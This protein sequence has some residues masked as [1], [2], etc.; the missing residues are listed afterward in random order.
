MYYLIPTV[1][2]VP[3]IEGDHFETSSPL[4]P[5]RVKGLGEGSLTGSAAAVVNAVADAITPL[6]L[7]VT[8]H[9][10]LSPAQ[11]LTLCKD[12]NGPG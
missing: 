2:D 12:T 8:K 7:K 1:N 3:Y 9:D 4:N 6:G 5:Y 10:P 11:V